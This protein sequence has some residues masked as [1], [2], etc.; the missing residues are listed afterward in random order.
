MRGSFC[1]FITLLPQHLQCHLKRDLPSRES[2]GQ[3]DL[4][5]LGSVDCKAAQQQLEQVRGAIVAK[6]T[7]SIHEC[8][9]DEGDLRNEDTEPGGNAH[10]D[11]RD[12][13]PVLALGVRW[14]TARTGVPDALLAPTLAREGV[15]ETDR[16]RDSESREED[17]DDNVKEDGKFHENINDGEDNNRHDLRAQLSVPQIRIN[18]PMRYAYDRDESLRLLLS[19]PRAVSKW[20]VSDDDNVGDEETKGQNRQYEDDDG[21]NFEERP[22]IEGGGSWLAITACDLRI[23][24]VYVL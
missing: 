22:E 13:L 2:Q 16:M 17:V 9:H 1:A 11:R 18:E 23:F 19:P 7:F 3:R 21:E 24:V 6:T 5:R 10:Q 14:I 8:S 12:E 4:P 20:G 15:N